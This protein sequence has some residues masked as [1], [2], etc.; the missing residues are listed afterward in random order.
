MRF[1]IVGQRIEVE[2]VIEGVVGSTRPGSPE[3]YRGSPRLASIPN[4]TWCVKAP[5]FQCFVPVPGISRRTF[6][7][8]R[9]LFPNRRDGV[10]TR[11]RSGN[12]G[13]VSDPETG[14]DPPPYVQ[15][16]V[17]ADATPGQRITDDGSNAA[18]IV[19][20]NCGIQALSTG[21]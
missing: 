21:T 9:S 10:W 3:T 17:V 19:K 12:S 14:S 1:G 16:N 11:I 7:K 6:R 5:H 8:H 15:M 4:P 20:E 13:Q 18:L 2:Y